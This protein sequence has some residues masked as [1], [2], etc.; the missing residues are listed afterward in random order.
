M[1]LPTFEPIQDTTKPH[2][3]SNSSNPKLMR[4]LGNKFVKYTSSNANGSTS[5]TSS[6]IPHTSSNCLPDL[7]FNDFQFNDYSLNFEAIDLCMPLNSAHILNEQIA[8]QQ[9][10]LQSSNLKYINANHS[11]TDAQRSNS[12]P[13]CTLNDFNDSFFFNTLSTSSDLI[14]ANANNHTDQFINDGLTNHEQ[15]SQALVEDK[16]KNVNSRPSL[17][18]CVNVNNDDNSNRDNAESSRG[19]TPRKKASKKPKISK[20]ERQAKVADIYGFDLVIKCLTL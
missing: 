5:S 9:Q 13:L 6:K 14:V 1:E 4:P 18:E 15:Q 17:V 3:P 20:V 11:K 12:V 8:Q 2:K 19:S 10:Q 7:T 16:D